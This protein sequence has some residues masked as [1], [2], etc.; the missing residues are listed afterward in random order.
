MK[1]IK[2]KKARI[3]SPNSKIYVITSQSKVLITGYKPYNI[4]VYEGELLSARQEWTGSNKIEYD[5]I[6]EASQYV[7]KPRQNGFLVIYIA[8]AFI[9]T[10]IVLLLTRNRFSFL[11]VLP[12]PLYIILYLTIW[13]NRVLIIEQEK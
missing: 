11:L 3:F 13:R 8:I 5:K 12:I 9:I 6:C 1:N 7:I 4:N 2:I 10:Y